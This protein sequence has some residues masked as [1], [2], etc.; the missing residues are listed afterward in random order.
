MMGPFFILAVITASAAI[1]GCF[2]LCWQ[3]L[4]QNGRILLRLEELEERLDQMEL[5]EP[6][7][8]AVN[9][10]L[11]ATSEDQ[12]ERPNRFKNHSLAGSKIGRN[13][14]KEGTPAPEFRLPRLDGRGELSLAELYGRRVLLVFSSPHCGPCNQLAPKLEEFHREQPELEL[15]MVSKGDPRENRVK[16][17]KHGLTFPVVL[18]RGWEISRRYAIFATPVAYLIDRNGDIVRDVAV[19]VD[20]ILKLLASIGSEAE[21]VLGMTAPRVVG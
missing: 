6:A 17:K 4:Q 10:E 8:S 16:V 7:E 14:L 1:L 3:M 21:E 5:G 13:G 18:Q 20:P 11:A 19:G 9:T 15:V 2:W 12:K